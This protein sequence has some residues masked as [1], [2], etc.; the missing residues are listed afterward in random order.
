MYRGMISLLCLLPSRLIQQTPYFP[1]HGS[2]LLEAPNACPLYSQAYLDRNQS[3]RGSSVPVSGVLLTSPPK[4]SLCTTTHLWSN[5]ATFPILACSSITH[6]DTRDLLPNSPV[7]EH[8]SLG[9]ITPR[10]LGKDTYV[11]AALES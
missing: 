8:H 6:S 7:V 9:R 10:A 11:E 4:C 2:R 1:V 5:I 3:D